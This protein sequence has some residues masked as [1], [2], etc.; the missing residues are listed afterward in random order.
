[1][2]II[3]N[4]EIIKKN[5]FLGSA[6]SGAELEFERFGGNGINSGSTK[7]SLQFLETFGLE[8]DIVQVKT[9]RG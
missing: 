6:V 5:S 8:T 1:M 3:L 7:L 9:T 4:H 2:N